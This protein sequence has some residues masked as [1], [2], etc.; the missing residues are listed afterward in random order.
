MATNMSV[1]ASGDPPDLGN[2]NSITGGSYGGYASAWGATYYSDRFAASVMFVGISEQISKIFTT[3]IPNESYLVHWRMRPWGNWQKY[4]EASPLYYVERAK[5]PI[6]ILHGEKDPRVPPRSRDFA[7]VRAPRPESAPIS[8][9][10]RG[11]S[12]QKPRAN[13]RGAISLR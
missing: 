6:L 12:C 10:L 5:T 8:P 4:L 2:N 1:R 7:A 11:A 3:D 13:P 9:P